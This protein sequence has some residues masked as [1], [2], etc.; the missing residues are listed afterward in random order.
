MTHNHSF[1]DKSHL[2]LVDGSSF[3]FRA[4]HAIPLLTRRDGLP[5][6]AVSGFC[7]M[8][9]RLID[10]CPVSEKPSHF[11]VIFD[12]KGG[13]FRHEIYPRY[14]AN[15]G[16]PPEE[17]VPQFSLVRKAVEAFSLLPL[18]VEGFEA[19]DLIASYTKAA[20]QKGARVT[21][22]TSDKDLMQL[23]GEKV[24][25]Y[26]SM[27]N[28]Y[29]S[30]SEVFEKFG[31]YPHQVADVQT[32]C[33]D[34]ADN[35]SGVLG[36]GPKTAAELITTFGNLETL[37]S[38][39][40]EIPQKKR[41]ESLLEAQ[42]MIPVFRKV[43]GL[44]DDMPLP[45]PLEDL[46][47]QEPDPRILFPFLK[48]LE[49]KTL[50]KRMANVFNADPDLFEI[51]Q[52][53]ALNWNNKES[54]FAFINDEQSE[55]SQ[56]SGQDFSFKIG[57]YVL[58]EYI[59]HPIDRTTYTLVET[60][61]DLKELTKKISQASVFAF[62]TETT[63]LTPRQADLVG[64]SFALEGGEA[65]YI[66]VGHTRLDDASRQLPKEIVLTAVKPYLEADHILKVGQ[67]LK[68]DMGILF[69]EGIHLI[70]YDDTLLMAY[71][72]YGLRY[73]NSLDA[74]AE[75]LLGHETL[76][77]ASIT[78]EGRKKISFSEVSLEIATAYAA[79]DADVTLRVWHILKKELLLEAQNR[80]YREIDLP[81][82]RV[83]AQ[84]EHEGIPVDISFLKGLSA[85]FKIDLERL[86]NEIYVL[87]G[88]T[89]LISSPKQL[90]EILFET[91][92]LGLQLRAKKTATGQYATGSD[93]L[94]E[95]AG[96]GFE[97]PQKVLEWRHLHKL[98]T[99]YTDALP[100]FVHYKTNRIH[101]SFSLAGTST[102]R[103]SSSDPN[104]QNIP[105][106]TEEGHKI[107]E[108]F[109]AEEG[110]TLVSADYSQ[111]ELR[112]LAHMANIPALI[113]AFAEGVDIHALTA[114]EIFNVPLAEVT[115]RIRREAKTINFGIIY[116]QS[117]FGLANQLQIPQYQA[118][119]YIELYFSRFPEIKEYMEQT[120]QQAREK[121]YVETLL[122]RRVFIKDIH[123]KQGALRAFAERSA[124]NAP[125]QGTAADIIRIAMKD[126][127]VWL[128][129]Q[130]LD[131]RLLL[132]VHDELV[133]HTPHKE[134]DMIV[135]DLKKIME[136]SIL[137]FLTLNVP[138]TVEVGCGDN[139]RLAH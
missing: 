66:P 44:V 54:V 114:S 107:R 68:Y 97:L 122:G 35:V 124:I 25:L 1:S 72:L 22:V 116:G 45:L 3:L 20:V 75:R 105:I 133:L 36:I 16:S 86:E 79:E 13:N 94:E 10:E 40:H 125:I 43:V 100:S 11:A 77:Y 32:L 55:N 92:G 42:E 126:V 28:K 80:L 117:A 115:P 121:G 112:L 101:S 139:W 7:Q 103:L 91:A 108:A 71:A 85:Q 84:M 93:I 39:L 81:L 46:F 110:Y 6:N 74:L 109:I 98:K 27:K 49:L 82:A 18:E 47:L 120:K 135:K 14:K 123:A 95:L 33:G 34:S 30:E 99:T 31:V 69:N 56:Q 60:E 136:N 88:K 113:K 19:D 130:N 129:N 37:F 38:K 2:Y 4:F 138:L 64:I 61:E 9:F 70:S 29:F 106:R 134:K 102:G 24:R 50:L 17:L 104:L 12:P 23:V 51:G 21:I 63:H 90:G 59:K 26:D 118:K 131:S 83:T 73:G 5:V 57:D 58:P 78:G 127:S 67:N 89:F 132:Q 8:L 111:I 53:P 76:S 15:R 87:A 62:D 128:K 52:D 119:Q 41:R 48:A 65:F 137:H 96:Q